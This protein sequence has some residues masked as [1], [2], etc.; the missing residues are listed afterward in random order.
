MKRLRIALSSTIVV[1]ALAGMPAEA[2]AQVSSTATGGAGGA[3]GSASGGTANGGTSTSTNTTTGT[4]NATGGTASV[5]AATSGNSQAADVSV[6]YITPAGATGLNGLAPGV[7]PVSGHV[8]SDNNVHYSGTTKVKN[9]PDVNV[10]GAASGPCNGTSG[11]LGVGIPGLAVGGNFSSVDK[12]CE[13]RETAR[14]AAMIGRMDVANAVLE[15]MSLVIDAMKAR[16]EREAVAQREAEK[17]AIARRDAAA[18]RTAREQESQAMRAQQQAG[19]DALTRQATMAKTND[20]LTFTGK[21][22]HGEEKTPQQVMAEETTARQAA[23]ASTVAADAPRVAAPAPQVIVPSAP[24]AAMTP[25][26]TAPVGAPASQPAATPVAAP[27]AAPATARPEPARAGREA[28]PLLVAQAPAGKP[29]AKPRGAAEAA[30]A[31]PRAAAKP[32]TPDGDAIRYA[33]GLGDDAT[34]TAA[35]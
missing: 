35:R 33:L 13:A 7:D 25:P 3:G 17:V 21:L 8:V 18:E 19:I 24:Q 26:A 23:A 20:T 1:A 11:G 29:V 27:V 31:R 16:D 10:S 14:V 22:T 12:G 28:A 4:S 2:V 30:E 15:N 9:T 32:R 5:G 34:T 6:N